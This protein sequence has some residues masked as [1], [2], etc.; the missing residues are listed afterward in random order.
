MYGTSE[1]RNSRLDCLKE[2]T[3]KSL[4]KHQGSLSR[5]PFPVRADCKQ[6]SGESI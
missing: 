4:E 1:E 2:K 6:T 5:F 3:K